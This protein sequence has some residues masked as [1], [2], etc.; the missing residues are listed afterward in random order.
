MDIERTYGVTVD[1]HLKPISWNRHPTIKVSLNDQV[2]DVTV[3][4]E[5]TVSFVAEAQQ[6]DQF[7]LSVEH[8]GKV[9]DD[10]DVTNNLDTAVVVD[11]I[12]LN[13]I[14][15][16]RFVWE[17]IYEPQYDPGYVEEYRRNGMELQRQVRHCN[18]LGWNGV[19]S[20]QFTAPVFTWIHNLENLGWV[21]D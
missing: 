11:R 5:M 7:T 1:V 6:G 14:D 10:H 20:M 8:Y 4:R 18:Y 12:T 9:P 16:R 19:W 15:S 3:D 2:K 13:G 17:G 21:Y